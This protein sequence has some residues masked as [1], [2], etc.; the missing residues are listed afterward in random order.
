[1][2][3]KKLYEKA[4]EEEIEFY[5]FSEWINFHLCQSIYNRDIEFIQTLKD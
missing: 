4:K 3:G 5:Q 1:M 2:N